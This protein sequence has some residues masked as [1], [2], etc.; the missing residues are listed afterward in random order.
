MPWFR[1]WMCYRERE[2]MHEAQKMCRHFISLLF[3]SPSFFRHFWWKLW[4]SFIL[5]YLS[6]RCNIRIYSISAANKLNLYIFITIFSVWD[7][8]NTRFRSTFFRVFGYSCHKEYFYIFFFSRYRCLCDIFY[9]FMFHSFCNNFYRWYVLSECMLFFRL[10]WDFAFTFFFCAQ[11]NEN[12]D[13][14]H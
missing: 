13:V 7:P 12:V 1:R 6:F 8:L 11:K 10:K 2:K 3:H 4:N 5:I 14:L 9:S